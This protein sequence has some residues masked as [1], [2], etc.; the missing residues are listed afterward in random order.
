MNE[1]GLKR[2]ELQQLTYGLCHFYYNW[3]GPIKVPAPC[4]YAH[5]I[6][7]FYMTIGVAKRGGGNDRNKNDSRCNPQ[8]ENAVKRKCVDVTAL[9]QKLHYL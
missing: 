8:Q 9:N 4:Q 3:A 1:S 7:D 5:K 2:I 6:A